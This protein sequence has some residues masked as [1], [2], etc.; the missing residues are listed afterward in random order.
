MVPGLDKL[1]LDK[2]VS[3]WQTTILHG[4]N[5]DGWDLLIISAF[6]LMLAYN[7]WQAHFRGRITGAWGSTLYAKTAP[8]LFAF[9]LIINYFLF[10]LLLFITVLIF[11]ARHC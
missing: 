3:C 9:V 2:K 6:L 1:G 8:R 10:L 5:G 7:A 4:G 11:D